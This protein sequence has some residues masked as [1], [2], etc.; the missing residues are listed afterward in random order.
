MEPVLIGVTKGQPSSIWKDRVSDGR[1]PG[2]NPTIQIW[3]YNDGSSRAMKV[4]GDS[5]RTTPV[6]ITSKHNRRI[7]GME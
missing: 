2:P 6:T 5:T 7:L 3:R 1:K 4:G